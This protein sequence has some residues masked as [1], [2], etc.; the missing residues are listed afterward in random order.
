MT[1]AEEVPESVRRE[2]RLALERAEAFGVR[3][4]RILRA[5]RDPQP[6]SLTVDLATGEGATPCPG[7]EG[8]GWRCIHQPWHTG[9]C[10]PWTEHPAYRARRTSDQP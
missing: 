6:Q 9:A 1:D 5:A 2:A 3:E 4:R 8:A 10:V 7:P